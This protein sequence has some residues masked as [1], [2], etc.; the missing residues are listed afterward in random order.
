[1]AHIRTTVT[2][3]T[4]DTTRLPDPLT[5]YAALTEAIRRLRLI[6]RIPERLRLERRHGYAGVDVFL[7]LLAFLCQRE[8]RGM[9]PFRE[10]FAAHAEHIAAIGGRDQWPTQASISRALNSLDLDQTEAFGEWVLAAATDGACFKTTAEIMHTDAAGRRWHILD[11]D[12]TATMFRQ[13]G[14]PEG[15]DMPSPRRRIEPQLARRGYQ[16]RKRGEVQLSRLTLQH[17]GSG[18]WLGAWSGPSNGPIRHGVE[19]AAAV[20]STW[21]VERT[22][23][24]LL[25]CDGGLSGAAGLGECTRAGVHF[26]TRVSHY[27]WLRKERGAEWRAAASWMP[28]DDSRSG[29]RREAAEFGAAHLVERRASGAEPG[30]VA[31]RIVVSRF[32]ND[33][34]RQGVGVVIEGWQYEM[35]ATSLDPAGWSPAAVVTTYYGRCAQ[36][37]RFAQEDRELGLDRTFSYNP[38]GQL[39]GCLVGLFLWNLETALGARMVP[40]SEA[41]PTLRP[42]SPPLPTEPAEEQAWLGDEEESPPDDE[43]NESEGPTVTAVVHRDR[44]EQDVMASTRR[45]AS[46]PTILAEAA[47]AVQQVLD[48]ER[49]ERW[50]AMHPGWTWPRTAAHPSCPRGEPSTPRGVRRIRTSV[51]VR[52]RV[53]A[54]NCKTC[55]LRSGCTSSE[56]PKFGKEVHIVLAPRALAEHDALQS[57]ANSSPKPRGRDRD[58]MHGLHGPRKSSSVTVVHGSSCSVDA[59]TRMPALA[60]TFLRRLARRLFTPQSC[61][62]RVEKV[63]DPVAEATPWLASGASQRQ[64][65]RCL[66]TQNLNRYGLPDGSVVEIDV[67]GG[68]ELA[69]LL[70]TLGPEAAMT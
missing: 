13:R 45:H 67:A 34:K 1:M 10:R 23:E 47:V 14:L 8:E 12:G 46:K 65:R 22:A 49:L 33:G 42:P 2:P 41:T 44:S 30:K 61:L 18:Q 68:V 26:L 9:R 36:E 25:R 39:F 3:E 35:F 55:P 53:A 43:I 11:L 38:A 56:D 19:R 52:F 4:P 60:P 50:L 7:F 59:P 16:G 40:L 6:D 21:R 27:Q 20:A 66:H 51:R 28:V 31:A 37:S 29:P 17:A 24:V 48:D 69:K 54:A 32:R 62:V 57:I 63:V 5:R 15:E 70:E 64:H 58:V